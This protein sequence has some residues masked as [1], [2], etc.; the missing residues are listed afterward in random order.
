MVTRACRYLGSIPRSASSSATHQRPGLDL[1]LSLQDVDLG[2]LLRG[3]VPRGDLV[4]IG[5]YL[6]DS[7][8]APDTYADDFSTVLLELGTEF[9]QAGDRE[10]ASLAYQ[11]GLYF[12]PQHE[13]LSSAFDALEAD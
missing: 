11:L 1:A 9:E 12:C 13:E 5:R 10:S 6:L 7:K 2:M 3:A 4:Q 8:R